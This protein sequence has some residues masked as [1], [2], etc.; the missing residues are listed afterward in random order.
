MMAS[1]QIASLAHAKD[2]PLRARVRF[3]RFGTTLAGRVVGISH[4]DPMRYDLRLDNGAL[5]ANVPEPEIETVIDASA[6]R[7]GS[8]QR[9]VVVSVPSAAWF[10]TEL[11]FAPRQASSTWR[12]F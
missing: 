12:I 3:N 11:R 4:D 6:A 9:G 10:P 7:S 1:H 2:I 8:R 5:V